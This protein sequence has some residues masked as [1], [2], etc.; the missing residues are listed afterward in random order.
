[1]NLDVNT[2]FFITIYVEAILGLLLLFAWIQNAGIRAVAWWG[3]AHL[4]RATSVVL[5]GASAF[6]V[7]NAWADLAC[8]LLFL[9]YAIN[10]TGAGVFD[11]R[12]PLDCDR[13]GN[14]ACV[15]SC[16]VADRLRGSADRA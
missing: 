16:P 13:A 11:G 4:V 3:C 8:I 1:M 9:A 10:W 12:K 5:S 14:V 7:G 6:T 2:L 15:E